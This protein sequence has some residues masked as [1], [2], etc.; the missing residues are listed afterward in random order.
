MWCING[1]YSV[2]AVTQYHLLHILR[3]EWAPAGAVQLLP[4]HPR[5]D[6]MRLR[7]EVMRKMAM[8]ASCAILCAF[9][10]R[11]SRQHAAMLHCID[12][13]VLRPS[14]P[15]RSS[16][17][18]SASRT[19]ALHRPYALAGGRKWSLSRGV[20]QNTSG[21][22]LRCATIRA[23]GQDWKRRCART[24]AARSGPRFGPHL[25]LLLA[26]YENLAAPNAIMQS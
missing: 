11:G 10:T 13:L 5:H 1:V 2:R 4:R 23:P 17:T 26:G 14:I 25:F 3:P 15:S 20:Y 8:G 18:L 7:G 16:P 24:A 22:D 9:S 6:L 19:R 21:T 12:S